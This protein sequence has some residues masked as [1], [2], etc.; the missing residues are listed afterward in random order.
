[1][2]PDNAAVPVAS[3]KLDGLTR[4]MFGN[5]WSFGIECE[6]QD[7]EVDP[8]GTPE[9]FGSFWLWVGGRVVGN[10]DSAEQLILAF[11]RLPWLA[12][13]SGDR[14]AVALPGET[15]LDKLDFVVWAR[16]GEDD[17]YD[18]ERWGAHDVKALRGRQL[19]CYEV[20]PCDSPWCDGWEAILVEQGDTETLIWRR[21]HGSCGGGAGGLTPSWPVRQGGACRVRLV[22]AISSRTGGARKAGHRRKAPS[23][24]AP[25]LIPSSLLTSLIPSSLLTSDNPVCNVSR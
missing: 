24:E 11:D 17:A 16:F 12:L 15:L 13:H 20:V 18:A 23:A 10:T 3:Y 22:C 8:W 19:G 6:V 25:L 7:C 4:Y 5:R 1:M 14:K 21:R 2:A 9:P